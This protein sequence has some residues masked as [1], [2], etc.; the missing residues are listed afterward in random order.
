MGN[1]DPRPGLSYSLAALLIAQLHDEEG[2][3]R[4]WCYCNARQPGKDGRT[5][6]FCLYHMDGAE[7]RWR[8]LAGRRAGDRSAPY[9]QKVTA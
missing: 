2:P 8:A 4:P 9:S 1:A 7:A 6:E 5:L 3:A